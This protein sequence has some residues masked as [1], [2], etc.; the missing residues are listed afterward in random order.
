MR[1]R[2]RCTLIGTTERFQK[3]ERRIS[4]VLII[5]FY[6]GMIETFHADN[7]EGKVIERYILDEIHQKYPKAYKQVGN[8]KDYDIHIPEID[9]TVEVK[10]DYKSKDTGN[11]V[12]E[13]EF[14]GKPSALS[15]TKADYWVFV[16]V[17]N[18]YWITV[19]NL[20]RAIMYNHIQLVEF[21]G[22]GDTKSKK[23]YLVPIEIIARYSD[24]INKNKHKPS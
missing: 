11:I 18:V 15:V 10:M 19:E 13:I 3:S 12:V 6:T 1:G 4:R 21:I 14:N 2:Q 23:A 7:E 22:T 5:D 24:K 16:T 20:N 9:T 8:F 17:K